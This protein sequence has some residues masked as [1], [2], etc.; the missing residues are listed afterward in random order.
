MKNYSMSLINQAI[1]LDAPISLRS[2]AEPIPAFV[3]SALADFVPQAICNV[4]CQPRHQVGHLPRKAQDA[5]GCVL[6]VQVR[7]AFR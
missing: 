4:S 3:N 2:G 7:E 6:V 1:Y 5:A